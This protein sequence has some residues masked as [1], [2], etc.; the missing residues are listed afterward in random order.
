MALPS[1]GLLRGHEDLVSALQR[2][3][4]WLWIAL[5]HYLA[6]L[7]REDVWHE[8]MT[9][10][11]VI[12]LVAFNLAAEWR[13]LYRPW[14]AERLTREVRV[15]ITT[16]LVVPPI[17]M[18][19]GFVTKTG[20]S[21]SRAVTLLWMFALT[22][23]LI[24]A[25]RVVG[26]VVVRQMRSHGKNRRTVA[27][28][29][30]TP[31]SEKL[32]QRVIE[33]PWLGMQ[34]SGL[35]DARSEERRYKFTEVNI[36]FAGNLEQLVMDAREGKIDII[37]IS[38]PLRA[39]ARIAA[40]LQALADTTATVY[41]TADFFTYDLLNARW[42]QIGNVP[43]V[44]IY[45][46]PF[47]G[48]AGYLKRVED[49]VI[50]TMILALI[51]IPMLFIAIAIKLT[52]KGPVFFVQ[53]RF[54]LN[55][56]PIRV[57]K[58]RSMTV[59]EDGDVIKQVTKNDQRVT[60]LGAFMRRTSL[61]ELPQFL[62]VITGEMSIVGPRPHAV[63]HNQSYRSLIKGYM[64]RHKVKPGITGWAQVNGFRGETDTLDKM[65]Q[66]VRYDLEYITDWHLGWDLKIILLTIFGSA[67]NRGA[68]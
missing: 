10:A 60:K 13:G 53:R 8:R 51:A 27:I 47:S 19:F 3:A 52:S 50:G 16:W 9:T 41:L 61:D 4:D 64:L 38:L 34:L 49:V 11:T 31:I 66:R 15:A 24:V 46:S 56:K 65:E 29:G 22:P 67:K 25:W 33:R 62:Q 37:Y 7:I 40:L 68:Y 32:C 5:G 59:C 58:F 42:H 39:E 57:L 2:F 18:A 1:K 23:A 30:A 17:L 21:F 26:R 44:S 36:P 6:C 43:L 63:A 12:A 35:Y 14:R 28:V 48:V 45:D 20:A 54:G 55:G